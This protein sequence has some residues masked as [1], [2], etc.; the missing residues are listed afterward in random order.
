MQGGLTAGGSRFSTVRSV[1]KGTKTGAA[2]VASAAAITVVIAETHWF[3][4]WLGAG[5]GEQCPAIEGARGGVRGHEI[6][7]G[8]KRGERGRAWL[9]SAAKG[10]STSLSST[11]KKP[12]VPL[13]IVHPSQFICTRSPTSGNSLGS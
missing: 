4:I 3:R 10:Y 9:V 12:K 2:T 11:S 1:W 8:R 6:C 13:G 5:D 7:G